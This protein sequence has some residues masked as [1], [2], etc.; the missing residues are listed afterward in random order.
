MTTIIKWLPEPISA[1]EL[2]AIIQSGCASGAYM[3]AVTYYTAKETMA[4]HGDAIMSFIDDHIGDINYQI[5]DES[6]GQVCCY[7][8][9]TAVE[10]LCSLHDSESDWDDGE[11]IV[12]HHTDHE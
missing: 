9:S 6:W 5:R 3:P 2:A 4:K 11:T 7:I 8:L 1:Y 10:I 12:L